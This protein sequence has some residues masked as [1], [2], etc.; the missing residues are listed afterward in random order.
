VAVCPTKD[1]LQFAL[2]QKTRLPSWAVAATIAIIFFGGVAAAKLPSHWDTRIPDDVLNQL[3][4][5]AN[6]QAHP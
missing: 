4:P 6:E 2:P 1:A 3:V 5:A